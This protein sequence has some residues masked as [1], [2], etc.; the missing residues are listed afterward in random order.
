MP[1]RSNKF[2]KLIYAIHKQLSDNATV[3][4]SKFLVDRGTGVERRG[5]TGSTSM[6]AYGPPPEAAGLADSPTDL[7][8]PARGASVSCLARG[9][10][11]LAGDQRPSSALARTGDRVRGAIPS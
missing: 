1:K 8:G 5:Q 11:A 2:Q 3:Y 7:L 6:A 10:K 4:E 9:T